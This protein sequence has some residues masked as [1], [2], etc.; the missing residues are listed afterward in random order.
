MRW[1]AILRPTGTSC[2][3]WHCDEFVV[4]QFV[5]IDVRLCVISFYAVLSYFL[6]LK[7]AQTFREELGKVTGGSG[8]HLLL[9]LWL[10]V[11]SRRCS[12]C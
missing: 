3:R 1:R 11:R 2:E 12:R 5:C 8:L 4:Y 7:T 9:R 10:R 6:C